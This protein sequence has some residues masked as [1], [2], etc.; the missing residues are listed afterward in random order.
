MQWNYSAYSVLLRGWCRT[1][2]VTSGLT[3]WTLVIITRAQ[4]TN[5]WNSLR[6]QDC[7]W[8]NCKRMHSRSIPIAVQ[9]CMNAH[10]FD[11][12]LTSNFNFALHRSISDA[13]T[14]SSKSCNE[15]SLVQSPPTQYPRD[16]AFRSTSRD[17]LQSGISRLSSVTPDKRTTLEHITVSYS[18]IPSSRLV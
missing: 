12:T 2:T 5:F 11:S 1:R 6:M 14:Q 18:P 8:D 9:R 7:W 16:P 15:I 4:P 13:N 3:Y 17:R 10:S